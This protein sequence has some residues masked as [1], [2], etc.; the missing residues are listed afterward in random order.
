MVRNITGRTTAAISGSIEEAIHQ[1]KVHPGETLPSVRALAST[2]KV[3]PVTVA[4]AYKVARQRGLVT[5][6]G[7]QGTRVAPHP[8][9]PVVKAAPH[10]TDGLV[11][12]ASGNPDPALLPSLDTAMRS[13]RVEP[14]L[15]GDPPEFRQ[16]ATFLQGELEADGIDARHLTVVGGTLDGIGRVLREHLRT[17]DRV[18]LED[19]GYAGVR[20]LVASEGLQELPFAVDEEGPVPSS[21]EDAIR[22]AHAV[23]VTLRAQN[24]RGGAVSKMRAGLLAR[25]L[26]RRARLLLIES[27]PLGPVADLPLVP[28]STATRGPWAFIRSTSKFL[29]PDLRLA[30]IAGDALTIARVEGR[31]ALGTRWVSTILQQLVLSLWSDPSNARLLARAA[32]VYAHRRRSLQHALA[33]CGLEAYG[34]SGFNV[35]L[36]VREETRVVQGLA[37]RGWA[38]QPGA[39]FRIR[40]TP[41]VRISAAGLD[42]ADATR[43]A[44]DIAGV[45]NASTRFA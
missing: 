26:K 37:E 27:D 39:R 15:Y 41:A 44:E 2:L 11:D 24:P 18:A 17:G 35:W 3:S 38:V 5:G 32:D 21:F 6:N 42:P 33:G 10:V 25:T 9:S 45:M 4:A 20:D 43:L 13:L 14:H 28:L 29:G 1:G 19:P 36:P 23:V 34:R 30:A 40:S 12:L 31:Q 22:R 7:R 8:P 16:L